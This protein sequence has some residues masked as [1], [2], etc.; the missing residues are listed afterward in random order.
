M[1]FAS[2][3]AGAGGLDLGLE[4]AGWACDYATDI[5]PAAIATLNANKGRRMQGVRALSEAVVEQADVRKLGGKAIL[6]RIGRARGAVPLLAG[7]PPCQSWSSAGRQLGLADP[8]G[9]LFEDYLRIAREIDA[10]WLLF[11][12]VRGLVTARGPD[13]VPGSALALIR[14]ALRKAGWQTKVNLLNAADYGVPQRRVRL[15]LI[16]YHEGDAPGFPQATHGGACGPSWVTLRECLLGIGPPTDNEI[17]RPTGKMKAELEA[18]S[19]GKGVKS[20]GKAETTRP[21]GH[22]GYKQGAFVADLDQAARTVTANAQ[23]DWIRDPDLGLRRL[24]PRECSAI[25]TFPACWTFVGSR[26]DHYR[27]AGNAVPP[28]FASALGAALI[29]Q[30][31]ATKSKGN[32]VTPSAPEPLPLRL[33]AAI[34]Y[35]IRDDAR[36]GESRRAAGA[37]RKSALEAA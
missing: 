23:Q 31:R 27:L 28:L 14:E 7:G 37:A 2:L 19:P 24:S 17:I 11:E 22:W 13:G 15:F 9:R 6:A 20:P 26:V 25:Q 36:N 16:G 30:A 3:F 32:R 35:T 18:V 29:D 21:G 8:R 33:Q 4:C 1:H 10:R 34:A 5:D 12:N